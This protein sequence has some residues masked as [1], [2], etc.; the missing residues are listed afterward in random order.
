MVPQSIQSFFEWFCLVP[1]HNLPPEVSIWDTHVTRQQKFSPYP[2]YHISSKKQEGPY[3]DQEKIPGA[4]V[5]CFMEKQMTR[6][7]RDLF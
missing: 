5:G 1:L 7:M 2:M 3:F 4:P 6:S